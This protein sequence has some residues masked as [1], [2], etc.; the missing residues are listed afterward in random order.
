MYHKNVESIFIN[1]NLPANILGILLRYIFKTQ[2]V[3]KSKQHNIPSNRVDNYSLWDY[4]LM[5]G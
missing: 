3:N 4:T 2:K 1:I 5:G